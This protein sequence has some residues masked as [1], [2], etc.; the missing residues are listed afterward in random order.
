MAGGRVENGVVTPAPMASAGRTADIGGNV[1]AGLHIAIIGSGSGAFAAAIR[2]V[3]EE[4]LQREAE[5]PRGRQE[6]SP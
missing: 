6:S 3:D 1:A 2:A 5:A 4:A